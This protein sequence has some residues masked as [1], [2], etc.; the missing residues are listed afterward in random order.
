MITLIDTTSFGHAGE[1]CAA[2]TVR[3]RR[4]RPQDGTGHTIGM[5]P[6]PATPVTADPRFLLG[7]RSLAVTD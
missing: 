7:S 4:M 6:A 5:V 3:E 2:P 1:F